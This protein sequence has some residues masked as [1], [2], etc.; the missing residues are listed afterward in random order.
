[1]GSLA[2]LLLAASTAWAAPTDKRVCRDVLDREAETQTSVHDVRDFIE[3]D[4]R[5]YTPGVLACLCE[6]GAHLELLQAARRQLLR[7]QSDEDSRSFSVSTADPLTPA[8]YQVAI[9][10]ARRLEEKANLREPLVLH[11]T[12]VEAPTWFSFGTFSQ[13][14]KRAEI[15]GLVLSSEDLLGRY[16]QEAPLP[17]GRLT[18]LLGS[19]ELQKA[20]LSRLEID[21]ERFLF[22]DL[23]K[24]DE[25]ALTLR[26]SLLDLRTGARGNKSTW[27][28]YAEVSNDRL[29]FLPTKAPL[30]PVCNPNLA[31][32]TSSTTSTTT[33]SRSRSTGGGG[34]GSGSGAW[35]GSRVGTVVAGLVVTAAGVAGIATSAAMYDPQLDVFDSTGNLILR[36][37]RNDALSTIGLAGGI[38][39]GAGG[40][41]AILGIALPEKI[42]RRR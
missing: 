29:E 11:A 10:L 41:T 1:M 5:P 4:T 17:K 42:W 8:E 26:W 21:F 27:Q 22:V 12:F 19:G 9:L 37:P 39:A 30:Q 24:G 40:V 18:R 32:A 6:N 35:S 36:H 33:P 7:A 28:G 34:S 38:A 13:I 16:A 25:Q 20:D 31:V 15:R 2:A 14:L 3:K 23:E